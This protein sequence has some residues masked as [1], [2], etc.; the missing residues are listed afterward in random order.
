MVY[1]S[2]RDS[3]FDNGRRADDS[4]RA[5]NGTGTHDRAGT[6]DGSRAHHGTGA[7]DCIARADGRDDRTDN[8]GGRACC[9]DRRRDDGDLRRKRDSVPEVMIDF[10]L[11][12]AEINFLA[13]VNFETTRAFCEGYITD[14]EPDFE[15]TV[16]DGDIARERT[17][18]GGEHSDKY[19]ETLALYRK[20]AE[21]ASEKDAI[22]FHSSAISVDGRAYVFTAKSGTG[23]S[24]HAA[25]WRKLLGERAVMINDD[26][27]LIRQI[28]GEYFV[29]GTPWNGKHRLGAN[30]SAKLH[31]ICIIGRGAENKIEKITQD[32]ALPRLLMQTF[33]PTDAEKTAR[34]L[35]TVVGM[36]ASVPIY[37]L[38]CNMDL[39]AAET[40]YGAMKG[41]NNET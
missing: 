22:L 30:I 21:C 14:G 37:K 6:D 27:P 35:Q 25:L 28:G 32:E 10:V 19:L 1:R 31:G 26:K 4:T 18:A 20:I 40:S 12:L 8:H 34:V 15:V 24:T 9:N 36:S 33:R 2:D 23:K 29:Y 7:D 39:S 17:A 5:H 13:H 16:S 3:A 38:K 41:E 11:R